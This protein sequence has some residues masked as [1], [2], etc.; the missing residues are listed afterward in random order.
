MIN[1]RIRRSNLK[2]KN[3]LCY[4]MT[5]KAIQIFLVTGKNYW[6][7]THTTDSTISYCLFRSLQ[8]V[9]NNKIFNNIDDVKS[10]IKLRKWK[11]AI[12]KKGGILLNKLT[13][14]NENLSFDFLKIFAVSN[15]IHSLVSL[16]CHTLQAY[17]LCVR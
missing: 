6:S 3:V 1:D 17:F 11:Q 5:M 9:L 13:S 14:F 7:L 4:T 16:S 10:P 2:T 12:D 15:S 8:T